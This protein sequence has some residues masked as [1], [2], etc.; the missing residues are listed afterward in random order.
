MKLSLCIHQFFNQY[1]PNLLGVSKYT[2]KTYRDTFALF[3]PFAADY[4]SIK[5]DSL[6]VDHL[7]VELVLAFLEHLQE[8]RH[9]CSKTR[10]VRLATLKSFA[11]MIRLMWPQEKE[12]AEKLLNL[13]S[14]RTQKTLIGF[15]TYEEIQKV[16]HVV[17]L[18]KKEGFRDYT[19]LHLL[20]DSGARAS[21]VASLKIDYFDAHNKTLG[22]L[23]KGNRYR[24]LHLW[25]K[26][27]QLMKL[28]LTKYR[29][30]PKLLYQDSFFINQ[31]GEELTRHG[32]NWLCKKYLALAL[33]KKRLKGLNPV[34]SFRHSCAINMLLCGDSIT[35][36]KNRLGHEHI[37]STMNYLRLS[38]LRK[39]EIQKKFIEYT[40]SI[41][42]EDPKIE[43]L[44]DWE[45]KKQILDWLDSL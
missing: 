7:S 32:I 25:K 13:P 9:N 26:T 16:F 8:G 42:S 6:R 24:L 40:Q 35:D 36:I 15:L 29:P 18:M 12:I 14:K 23:G 11:K 33:P 45:N 21:E 44:L 38:L 3:L 43:E 19:I 4:L 37:D 41:L 30:T 10:N 34:H 17:D 5:I 27:T 31:R 39:R 22:I 1:L 28:Y 2:I 20:F